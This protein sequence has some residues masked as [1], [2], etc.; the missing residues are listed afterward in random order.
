MKSRV[1]LK[2]NLYRNLNKKG[3][4]I[5]NIVEIVEYDYAGGLFDIVMLILVNLY[6]LLPI[7]IL[8]FIARVLWLIYKLEKKKHDEKDD[9]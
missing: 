8:L 7:F 1:Y 3:I 5:M 9:I 6:H 4:L 2:N